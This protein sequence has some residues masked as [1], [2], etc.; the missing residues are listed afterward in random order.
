MNSLQFKLFL[1]L[2]LLAA[3]SLDATVSH[4]L[5]ATAEARVNIDENGQ[6][7]NTS[8][9]L[10]VGDGTPNNVFKSVWEFS[11]EPL[12][13][14][15]ELEKVY[16]R[17]RPEA[18]LNAPFDLN[19]IALDQ[20]GAPGIQAEDGHASGRV[21][22][23]LPASGLEE[24]KSKFIDVT[25]PLQ[26]ALDA[27]AERWKLR[28]EVANPALVS[29]MDDT[30]DAFRF[31]KGAGALVV[32]G[33]KPVARQLG[34][35]HRFDRFSAFRLNDGQPIINQDLFASA[36]VDREGRN[37]N[38]PSLIRVPD[39]I[40]PA[41][42]A[43]PAATYYLYF[44][45]HRGDYIRMAWAADLAGPYHLYRSGGG[46]ASG[47]RG[48]LDLGPDDLIEPGNGVEVRDHIASPDMFIDDVNQQ[49]VMYFHAP[50]RGGQKSFVATSANGL[51]FRMPDEGG[52]TGH[53]IRPV[54][55]G[56]PYY[57]VFDYDGEIYA[58]VVWGDTFKAPAN[59]WSP[60]P[61]FDYSKDYWTEG[62][63]PFAP[64]LATGGQGELRPRHYAVHREGNEL[65]LFY[66]RIGDRPERILMSTLDLGANDRDWLAWD[67]SFPPEE[68]L[69][70]EES[71]EGADYPP[72]PSQSSAGTGVHQLRD[73]GIFKD[74]EGKLYLLYS[75]AGEE[76][77]GLA[78]LARLPA[79]S[80][81]QTLLQTGTAYSF[82][83][84]HEPDIIPESSR[85]YQGVR[86]S[87]PLDA[88][89]VEPAFVYDGAGGYAVQQSSRVLEG[90]ASYH[91]AH[92][93]SGQQEALKITP[94]LYAG[95]NAGLTLKT[96]LL[97]AS[98]G[99]Y[100]AIQI[101]RDNGATWSDV[102]MR[103]GGT[104]QP[105]P[106]DLLLSLSSLA[107]QIIHLRF[108]YA[109]DPLLDSEVVTSAGEDAGWFL[110]GIRLIDMES[111]TLQDEQTLANGQTEL[112]FTPP[113]EGRY[114]LSVNGTFN[115]QPT[116]FGPPFAVRA[117]DDPPSARTSNARMSQDH[118]TFDLELDPRLDSS[119]VVK[120]TPDLHEP[121]SPINNASIL[122]MDGN[123]LQISIPIGSEVANQ[124][125]QVEYAPL[126][127]TVHP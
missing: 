104:V 19:L 36:E 11:L 8:S 91:L 106:E 88:E 53:G 109:H 63:N 102:W 79:L 96:Q 29:D 124:F 50:S 43:D 58:Q 24:D 117:Y 70:P 110:D 72:A 13:D 82:E 57:R 78:R 17:I 15:A 115:G 84:H 39:W 123:L 40:P 81:D 27:G 112:S 77:I 26:Q 42:R 103:R 20:A 55:L 67:T 94:P 21:L 105:Q 126:Q 83:I 4:T 68:I 6:G 33:S 30:P 62:T 121:M 97:E 5:P 64:D 122:P 118:F 22:T 9:N 12:E 60:A 7:K 47:E 85:L 48:V 38:G 116:E 101:S 90:S 100:A 89:K 46:F 95:P 98:P 14:F 65:Y 56:R 74:A 119:V 71:W 45:D 76:A 10:L 80:G 1:P 25:T 23:F 66:S 49:I 52:Q 75:G 32:L 114:Y 69:H 44:A 28:L 61:G 92:A 111:L 107:G 93:A 2:L 125:F 86:W 3:P 99:Q 41:N 37:I 34:R 87:T 54:M 31:E 51:N 59:P 16:F 127:E 120:S 35:V 73:P 18:K 108:L 113:T